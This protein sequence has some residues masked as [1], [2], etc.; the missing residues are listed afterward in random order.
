MWNADKTIHFWELSINASFY[1]SLLTEKNF[2]KYVRNIT[3]LAGKDFG[4]V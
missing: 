4:D 2:T 3:T 1:F